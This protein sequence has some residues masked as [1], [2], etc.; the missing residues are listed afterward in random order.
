MTDGGAPPDPAPA[1]GPPASRAGAAPV[2]LRPHHVLCAIGY[3]G[4]GYSDAFTANMSELVLGRLRGPQGD[5]T[6][7]VITGSADA[8]CAPCPSR[9]GSGCEQQ[10]RIDRLDQAHA[11]ALGLAPGDRLTWAEAQARVQARVRPGSLQQLCAGCAWL[12]LGL[13]ETALARLHE[14][15][16]PEG[17]P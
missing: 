7:L 6:P 2:A 8:I 4:L 9:R 17:S 10:A 11:A 5:A 1:A 12:P 14:K 3:Q 16:D 15:G 13:C